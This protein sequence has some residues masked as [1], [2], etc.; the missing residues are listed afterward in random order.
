[1]N[2]PTAP[3]SRTGSTNDVMPARPTWVKVFG[4]IFVVLA[5]TFAVIHLTGN[6][7]QRHTHEPNSSTAHRP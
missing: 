3:P 4:G 5:V 1:M 2:D 7:P 6:G